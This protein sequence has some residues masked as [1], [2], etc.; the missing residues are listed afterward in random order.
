MIDGISTCHAKYM[1]VG[2]LPSPTPQKC[3]I[4]QKSMERNK[5][6]QIWPIFRAIVPPNPRRSSPVPGIT[7]AR[8]RVHVVNNKTKQNQKKK[9]KKQKTNQKKQKTNQKKLYIKKNKPKKLKREKEKGERTKAFICCICAQRAVPDCVIA[10][11]SISFARHRVHV[12]RQKGSCRIARIHV[13]I[14]RQGETVRRVVDFAVDGSGEGGAGGVEGELVGT[15][16]EG[17]GGCGDFRIGKG[18][19]CVILNLCV[20]YKRK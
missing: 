20:T 15:G 11:V 10:D 6:V 8:H 16:V 5:M 9:Q 13:R 17:R 7:S 14:R 1:H 12:C 19:I 18:S 2:W 4:T 3:M